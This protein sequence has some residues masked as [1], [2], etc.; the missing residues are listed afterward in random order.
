MVIA[1]IDYS[2]CGPAICVYD[3]NEPRF[4]FKKCSFFYLTSRKRLATEFYNN[5]R[6]EVFEDY[7]HDCE[8]YETI[9]DWATDKVIGCTEILLE[10]YAFA[11]K[12]RVFNIAE[13]TGLLKYKLYHRGI[14]TDVVA[15]TTIKKMATGKGNADKNMMHDSFMLE[16]SVD[17]KGLI[18]PTKKNAE[19][20]V[21]DLVD[22]FYI[23]KYL[24]RK[25][26]GEPL[27]DFNEVADR[28]DDM[29]DENDKLY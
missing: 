22:S 4:I 21:S 29:D 18:T 14:P 11:A 3:T 24:Y 7:N 20:P 13:N 28:D 12:G 19:S 17:L 8:R 16:T 1:G 2:L 27:I 15:P 10:G 23:C 9:A 26:R 25:M 6:G 5:I